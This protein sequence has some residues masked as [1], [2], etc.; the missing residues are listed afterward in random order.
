MYTNFVV[1]IFFN[2]FVQWFSIR[3]QIFAMS[4]DLE[5]SSI[6]GYLLYTDPLKNDQQLYFPEEVELI[7]VEEGKNMLQDYLLMKTI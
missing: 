5:I 6:A 4:N 7:E 3:I 2:T 1:F